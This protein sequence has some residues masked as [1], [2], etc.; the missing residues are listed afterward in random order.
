MAIYVNLDDDVIAIDIIIRKEY[1][2]AY[3]KWSLESKRNALDIT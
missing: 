1:L 3:Q 2:V